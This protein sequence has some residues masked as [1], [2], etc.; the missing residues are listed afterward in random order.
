MVD[1]RPC[2]ISTPAVWETAIAEAANEDMLVYPNGSRDQV[3][4]CKSTVF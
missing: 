3:G 4:R 1:L 2:T